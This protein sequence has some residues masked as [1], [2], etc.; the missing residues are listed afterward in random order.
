MSYNGRFISFTTVVEKAFRDSGLEQIDFEN[1]MEWTVEL[2][3][4]M[5]TPY[6]YV[7]KVTDGMNGMP[8]GLKVEN[9]RCKLPD[10]LE[11][12]Q[13]VRKA[14]IDENGEI[15]G[16]S[17]MV[18]SSNLFHPIRQVNNQTTTPNQW[19]PLVNLDTF[20]PATENFVYERVPVQID[21]PSMVNGEP[22]CYKLDHGYIFT[23]FE[24]GYVIASYRG[25]PIDA[26]GFPMIPEDQKFQEAL[27]WHLIYKIDYR[28]WRLNPSPQNA[29]I[30][31]DSELQR[32][33][34]VGAARNKSHIPSI[35]KME[36]I[37]NMWVRSIPKMN[38]HKNGF[39]SMNIQ[40]QRY[41]QRYQPSRHRRNI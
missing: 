9:Y 3:G 6:V 24:S 21:Q 4:L 34:Y 22:Y 41:N 20:D 19:D 10:D 40:E 35:D 29:A 12:L 36:A 18:E 1:A 32:D 31:N 14:A 16:T 25:L 26:D 39:Y 13:S 17:E 27:K 15:T 23:N 33:W 11:I 8:T 30:K 37:K 38:E 28:N 5:G 2:F 7:D